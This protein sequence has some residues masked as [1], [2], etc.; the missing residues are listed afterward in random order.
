MPSHKPQHIISLSF[1][2]ECRCV[3]SLA[4]YFE[5][6]GVS[7]FLFMEHVVAT[8][9]YKYRQLFEIDTDAAPFNE[10]WGLCNSNPFMTAQW[11][12]VYRMIMDDPKSSWFIIQHIHLS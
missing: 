1:F 12:H 5:T 6:C 2:P 7:G 10:D 11:Q 3:E 4:A 8:G 9:S